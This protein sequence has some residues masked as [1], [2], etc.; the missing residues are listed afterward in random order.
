[1]FYGIYPARRAAR[2]DPIEALRV[3]T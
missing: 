1:L 3:E 2:L